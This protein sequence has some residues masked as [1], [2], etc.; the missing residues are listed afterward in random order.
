[1]I[2][3][4][5]ICLTIKTIVMDKDPTTIN[6]MKAWSRLYKHSGLLMELEELFIKMEEFM[7]VKLNL[8]QDT[9]SGD[10][11]ILM[12]HTLLVSTSLM[13]I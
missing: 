9:G 4:N 5:T 10:I 3:A 11:F 13:N 8:D 7:K 2:L 6:Y 1:M 12:A